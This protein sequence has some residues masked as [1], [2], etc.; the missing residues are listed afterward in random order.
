MIACS[1]F[2]AARQLGAVARAK[3][4]TGLER[5]VAEADV[6]VRELELDLVRLVLPLLE[7]RA[8][9]VEDLPRRVEVVLGLTLV[10]LFL[11]VLVVVLLHLRRLPKEVDGL[12]FLCG[13]R[14]GQERAAPARL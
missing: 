3:A 13:A 10:A 2:S 11:V 9:E 7:Q 6:G 14:E 8:R 1:N 4:R 5:D 12:V